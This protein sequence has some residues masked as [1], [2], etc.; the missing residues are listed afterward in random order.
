ML[1]LAVVVGEPYHL[2]DGT[3]RLGGC[4][5]T[6]PDVGLEHR[7]VVQS[8]TLVDVGQHTPLVEQVL[9]EEV[10]TVVGR[11][12]EHQPAN[13][14]G[15][16]EGEIDRNPSPHRRAGHNGR[17]QLQIIEESGKIRGVAELTFAVCRSAEAP[18]V[19]PHDPPVAGEPVRLGLPHPCVC[20]PGVNQNERVPRTLIKERQPRH[21]VD[22]LPLAQ[23]QTYTTEEQPES[24]RG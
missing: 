2:S 14:I 21:A 10:K 8:A 4:V 7:R 17:R 13:E 1:D 16:F 15:A 19:G 6:R 11:A 12:D 3:F 20:N 23:R 22:V 9:L 18:Q 5:R 24:E